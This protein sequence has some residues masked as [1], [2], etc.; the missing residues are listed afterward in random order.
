MIEKLGRLYVLVKKGMTFAI[1]NTF[2]GIII[3]S[4]DLIKAIAKA[5]RL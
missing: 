4:Y 3:C 2:G 1:R 5:L